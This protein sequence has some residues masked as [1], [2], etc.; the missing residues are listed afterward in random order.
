MSYFEPRRASFTYRGHSDLSTALCITFASYTTA[1]LQD[2]TPES[3]AGAADIAKYGRPAPWPQD[4]TAFVALNAG[5]GGQGG[6][7]FTISPPFIVRYVTLST[8]RTHRP[9][10]TPTQSTVDKCVDL[11]TRKLHAGLNSIHLFQYRDHSDRAFLALLHH[12]TRAQLAELQTARDR[13]RE[14]RQFLHGLGH[15]ELQVPRLFPA[16]L[17][18]SSFVSPS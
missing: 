18:G 17:L 14:W 4:G 16:S 6:E 13:E 10:T 1:Q 11:G 2:V 8:T 12:P 5:E 9:L 15:I 7:R 3:P